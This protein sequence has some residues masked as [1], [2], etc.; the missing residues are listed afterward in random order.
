MA[1]YPLG[2]D[3]IFDRSV[4]EAMN[5]LDELPG[6]VVFSPRLFKASDLQGSLAQ[7]QLSPEKLVEYGLTAT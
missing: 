4:R 1:I 5:T 7:H 3:L 2:Q 6:T